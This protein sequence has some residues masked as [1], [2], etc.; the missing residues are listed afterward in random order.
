MAAIQPRAPGGAALTIA[1][2]ASKRFI[3]RSSRKRKNR[4]VETARFLRSAITADSLIRQ[5]SLFPFSDADIT[6]GVAEIPHQRPH[7][8]SHCDCR[9]TCR[10][11]ESN[12]R[13]QLYKGCAL[14]TELNRRAIPLPPPL[15][16]PQ[17]LPCIAAS[18]PEKVRKSYRFAVDP[19]SVLIQYAETHG[20]LRVLASATV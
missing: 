17:A 11:W 13:H 9:K 19:C 8:I 15:P 2:N 14:P 6:C 10:L 3:G 7:A 1:T 18:G 20:F 5:A 4:C 16:D 12:S